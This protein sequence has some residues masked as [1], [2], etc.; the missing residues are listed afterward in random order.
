M[1]K[2]FS[3]EAPHIVVICLVVLVILLLIL[4]LFLIKKKRKPKGVKVNN[5][6]IDLLVENYG[7]I[8]NITNVEIE[9]S[10]LKIT[11]DDLDLVKL[12]NL[13]E[14]AESGIFVTGNTVKTLYKLSS[15][16]IKNA[17]EGRLK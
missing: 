5:E 1:Q 16:Q 8:N 13:K 11:V 6:F 14:Q 15:E 3:I 17:L 2:I 12:D 4:A 7:G 10:R 9:N